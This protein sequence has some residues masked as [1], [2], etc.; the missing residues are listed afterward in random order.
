MVDESIILSKRAKKLR[1]GQE[2]VPGTLTVTD[3]RLVWRPRDADA[4]SECAILLTSIKSMFFGV[5]L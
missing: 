4:G 5:C 3:S 1:K 2:D